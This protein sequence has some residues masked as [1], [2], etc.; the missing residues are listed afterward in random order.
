MK[1]PPDLTVVPPHIQQAIDLLLSPYG[2]SLAT[3]R[4]HAM[5]P[6]RRYLRAGEAAEYAQLSTTT[7]WRMARDGRLPAIKCGG[8]ILYDAADIDRLMRSCKTR[9]VGKTSM[10]G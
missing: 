4:E 1:Q 3:F 9:G 6:V 8:R 7:L 2:L 5:Q 10:T